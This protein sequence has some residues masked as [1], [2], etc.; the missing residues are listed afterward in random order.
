MPDSKKSAT[1]T[2]VGFAVVQGRYSGGYNVRC[3]TRYDER[4]AVEVDYVRLVYTEMVDCILAH[5]D[6]NR[7]GTV[8][9]HF[10]TQHTLDDAD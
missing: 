6:H 8:E 4:P 1:I 7:P 5:L 2:A 9:G 3:W 10:W